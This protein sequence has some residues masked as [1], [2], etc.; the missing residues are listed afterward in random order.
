MNDKQ[1]SI[2]RLVPRAPTNRSLTFISFS[3]RALTTKNSMPFLKI[4]FFELFDSLSTEL[5]GS[6]LIFPI[7]FFHFST[8]LSCFYRF[9]FIIFL[10]FSICS[11]VLLFFSFPLQIFEVSFLFF[12]F[13]FSANFFFKGFK[14]LQ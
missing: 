2:V 6:F 5:R 4:F 10:P 1:I 8:S 7:P 12:F 13:S 14:R 11:F 9:L 3:E